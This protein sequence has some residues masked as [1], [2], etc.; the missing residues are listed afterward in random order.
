MSFSCFLKAPKIS[1]FCFSNR[2]AV[3]SSAPTVALVSLVFEISSAF[4]SPENY[5]TKRW[6]QSEEGHSIKKKEKIL[7]KVIRKVIILKGIH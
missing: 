1:A 7:K 4:A 6:P 3:A 2:F 5:I